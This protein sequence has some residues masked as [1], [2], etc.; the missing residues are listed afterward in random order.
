MAVITLAELSV[1]IIW[2]RYFGIKTQFTWGKKKAWWIG[3]ANFVPGDF[4]SLAC[5]AGFCP[6]CAEGGWGPAAGREWECGDVL[7]SPRGRG[8]FWGRSFMHRVLD[9]L[10]MLW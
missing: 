9:Y 5:L 3:V 2:Q 8:G 7:G 10:F 1:K 4:C 6:L